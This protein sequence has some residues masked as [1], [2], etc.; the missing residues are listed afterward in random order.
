MTRT[1]DAALTPAA[2]RIL[3]TA[4]ALFYAHGIT[5]VG[6]DMIATESGITKRTLYDRFGSKDALVVAYLRDR[7]VRWWGRWEERLAQATAPRALTVFDSYADDVRPSGRGCAFINA[8]AELAESH[9]GRVVIRKHKLR[10]R[11]RL[12]EL[13][14][15]DGVDDPVAVAE[16]VFLLLEG[17]IAHQGIDGNT[18]RLRGARRIAEALLEA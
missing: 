7:D 11:T 4:S 14:R 18:T 16:H 17:A 10:V 8:A 5:A 3:D 12:E 1:D 13:I 2:R 6:V 15:E 9:P